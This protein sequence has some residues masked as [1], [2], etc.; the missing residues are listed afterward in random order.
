MA[1]DAEGE[2]KLALLRNYLQEYGRDPAGFG[3]EAWIRA[4]SPDPE[5]WA[6]DLAAWR[7]L[8]AKIAMLYPFYR[9]PDFD[10]RIDL[11]R[12]F[13]EIAAG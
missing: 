6:A 7:R 13:K 1:P 4:K 3:L 5:G 2:A 9:I 12:Q 11:L 10:A 8:G